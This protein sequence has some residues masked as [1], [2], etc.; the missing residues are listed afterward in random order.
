MN[1][2]AVFQMELALQEIMRMMLSLV[3]VVVA[4]Q[5][6]LVPEEEDDED[7]YFG[8]GNYDVT[9]E[10]GEGGGGE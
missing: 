2:E 6:S 5:K 3:Q 1:K 4:L 9:T 10:G 7:N 8:H